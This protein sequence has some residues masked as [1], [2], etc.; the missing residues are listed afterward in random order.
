MLLIF[1]LFSF[2]AAFSHDVLAS[3]L[4]LIPGGIYSMGN[5]FTN[6]YPNEGFDSELPPHEVPVA[7]FFIGRFEITNEEM[8]ETLQWAYTNGLVDVGN[9]IVTN[10]GE[11]FTNVVT[12]LNGTVWNT[13]GGHYEL[14]DLDSGYCQ[15]LFTNDSFSIVPGKTNFPCI[16][17]TWHG[18]LAFC[19]YLSDQEGLIRAVDFAATN[20][21]VDIRQDG[22][23]LPTEAE[24]EK[25]CRGGTPGT[26][27]PWPDD[28]VQ[29]TN[30]YLYSIDPRK[31]NYLD[32]RYGSISNHPGH[33]WFGEPVR[34]TP[35]GYYNGAQVVTNWSIGI[36]YQGADY[37]AV[38][39]MVNGYG[40]YD[41]AGNAYEWCA[42]YLSTNWY[43]QME[44][45]WPDPMGPDRLDSFHTQRVVRGGGW[46]SYSVLKVPDPSFQRCSFRVSFPATYSG[47]F[48][49]FRVARRFQLAG[50]STAGDQFTMTYGGISGD[51]YVV[52]SATNLTDAAPWTPIALVTNSGTGTEEIQLDFDGGRR[53]YRLQT[54]PK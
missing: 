38:E 16:E 4:A 31:A 10:T 14:M 41:M 25:A 53:L 52:E 49:G 36:S 5:S 15:V 32:A 47:T 42:D 27:Y 6:L 35:V 39:D 23:R 21:T 11:G 48:V 29:G 43:S 40:L 3:E 22:Y 13:E 45:S 1:G 33:P 19:N 12:N 8:T 24:W 34:T 44:S 37:G 9:A 7:P 26:H 2:L 18:A 51:V 17:V 28:S 30:L 20:W 46:A 54:A 50:A